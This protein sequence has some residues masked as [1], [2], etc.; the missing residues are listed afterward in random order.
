MDGSQ[1]ALPTSGHRILT[2]LYPFNP[3]SC[4]SSGD[5]HVTLSFL[6]KLHCISYSGIWLSFKESQ[7]KPKPKS[8]GK[9]NVYAGLPE[10]Q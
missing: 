10:V 5:D 1:G 6:N 7:N 4:G 2:Y 8:G 3:L 9:S